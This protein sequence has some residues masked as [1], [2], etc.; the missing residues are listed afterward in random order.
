MDTQ[1]TQILIKNN[2]FIY[3]TLNPW[4]QIQKFKK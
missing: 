3:N 4:C 1:Y 2:K